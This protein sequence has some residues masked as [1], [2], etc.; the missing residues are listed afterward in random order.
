MADISTELQAIMNAKYGE[1]VRSAI[2]NA[3]DKMNEIDED[4]E[5]YAVGTRNGTDVDSD[6]PAY[7][8]NAKYYAEG[9]AE[10]ASQ[11]ASSAEAPLANEAAVFSSSASYPAGSHV[12]YNNYL[13][14]FTAP[15][16]GDWTG[17]DVVAT[18]LA[19]A[20]DELN[21]AVGRTEIITSYG[22]IDWW[23]NGYIRSSGSRGSVGD[24]SVNAITTALLGDGKRYRYDIE[25]GFKVVSIGEYTSSTPNPSPFVGFVTRTGYIDMVQG[26][27]YFIVIGTDPAG[28]DI[29][30]DR[31]LDD[32]TLQLVNVEL[33]YSHLYYDAETVQQAAEDSASALANEAAEFDATVT[34]PV[35]S[36]VLYEGDLYRFTAA[37]SGAWLGTDTVSVT[38]SGDMQSGFGGLRDDVDEIN[39]AL[40]KTTI[41]TPY[42]TISGWANGYIYN[43]T[44]PNPGAIGSSNVNLYTPMLLGDGKRYRY[45]IESGFKVVAIGEYTGNAATTA[46]WVGFVT[47]TGY[48]DMVAGNYYIFVIANDAGTA[49]RPEDVDDETLQL[50]NTS[51]VYTNLSN[52]TP[53]LSAEQQAALKSVATGYANIVANFNYLTSATMNDYASSNTAY[54]NDKFKI[55]CSLLA[56]LIWM[57]R[58]AEDF[59]DLN[60]YSPSVTKLLDFGYY[61]QFADRALYGL[62]DGED[63]YGFRNPFDDPDFKGSYSWNSYYDVNS[64]RTKKQRFNPFLFANDMAKEMD[65]IGC[66]IKISE[67][68]PGDLIFTAGPVLQDQSNNFEC[69]AYKQINHVAMIYEKDGSHL[70]IIE[71]TSRFP[72]TAIKISSSVGTD[73]E[74]LRVSFL[75]SRVVQCA[76]HPAAFGFAE[77]V[78]STITTR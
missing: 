45:D 18:K 58:S 74:K 50:I 60:S 22:T 34:Y 37:H 41:I 46:N 47:R 8:N 43:N 27:Y 11:A 24:S 49:I 36:Y 64:A 70:S 1:Q 51:V 13:Y 65:R 66:S 28:S 59:A 14:Q 62:M 77:N 30:I 44:K 5:A 6:D 73:L 15:H 69:V 12:L 48:L 63:Y 76:R 16:S 2:H 38:L 54:T 33:E 57:G 26:H 67:L 17:T 78:P 55:C 4:A 52:S 53:V 35:G 31:D 39:N 23:K 3:L 20:I 7:H 21:V 72:G 10:S 42:G 68:Q 9:A 32:T 75:M 56:G 19:S 40:G 25:S 71:S 29:D 61:F